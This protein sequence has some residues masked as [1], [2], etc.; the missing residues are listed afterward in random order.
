MNL[1]LFRKILRLCVDVL[2]A[3]SHGGG[4]P[5]VG[6]VTRIG[7]VTLLSIYSLTLMMFTFYTFTLPRLFGVPHLHVNRP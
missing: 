7:G 5:Q 1:L 3:C 6:E 4:G 2:R